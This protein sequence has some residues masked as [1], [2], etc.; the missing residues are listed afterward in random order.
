MKTEELKPTKD[1]EWSAESMLIEKVNSNRRL[2]HVTWGVFLALL[3]FFMWNVDQAKSAANQARLECREIEKNVADKD[4]SIAEMG[5]DIK[6][7][8]EKIDDISKSIKK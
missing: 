3:V 6:Y 5:K 1:N 2:I 4:V 8:R 7:L